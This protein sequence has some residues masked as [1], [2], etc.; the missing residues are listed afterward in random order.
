MHSYTLGQKKIY[1]RTFEINISGCVARYM[2]K[3]NVFTR[4]FCNLINVFKFLF[5]T[6]V[7]QN[8]GAEVPE[9]TV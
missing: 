2:F 1:I 8:I 4:A 9:K 5:V 7:S 6:V 3:Q